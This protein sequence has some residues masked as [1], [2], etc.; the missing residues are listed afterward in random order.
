MSLDYLKRLNQ[1]YDEWIDSY[2]EGPLLVINA[3]DLDFEKSPED[4]GKIIELVG[5]HING[6]F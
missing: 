1:K 6:L 5:S 3:D 4:M 2:K